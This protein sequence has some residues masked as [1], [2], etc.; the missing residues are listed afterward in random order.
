LAL[1]LGGCASGIT[2]P[3]PDLPKSHVSSSLSPQD[4]KK[5]VDDLTKAGDTHEQEAQEQ[6][7]SSR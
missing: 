1:A 7:E 4:R 5:A 3:L 6:I 2:T